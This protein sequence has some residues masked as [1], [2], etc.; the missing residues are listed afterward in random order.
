MVSSSS[1]QNATGSFLMQQAFIGELTATWEPEHA[2]EIATQQ[3]RRERLPGLVLL[4]FV[5]NGS[6]GDPK[7]QS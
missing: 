1:D 6:D 2:N 3:A 7:N 4:D 5:R